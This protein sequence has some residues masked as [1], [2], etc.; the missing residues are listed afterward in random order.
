LVLFEDYDGNWQRYEDEIFARFYTDFIESQPLFLCEPVH[1]T[2]KPLKKGKERG[3]WHC[4]QEGRIEEERMP[5]IRR[6]ERI[7]WARAVIEHAD[8][9]IIKVW[10]KQVGRKNRY[11]LWIEEADYLVI[12]EKRPCKWF[13]WTTYYTNYE[14][15][16]TKL[17]R[18]YEAHKKPTPS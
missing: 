4:I 10:P 14:R 1:A 2:K 8:D 9:P 7:C 16:R 15:T 13:L 11:M 6:C 5:D 12:L 3:F 18:E 17:R